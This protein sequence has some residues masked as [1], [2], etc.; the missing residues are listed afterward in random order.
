MA[1][2]RQRIDWFTNDFLRRF[3]RDGFDFNAAFSAGNNH[4][5]S[6][7]SVEQDSEINLARDVGG[8]GY[9]HFVNLATTRSGLVRDKDLT[10]HLRRDL[11]H[12]RRRLANM[13]PAFESIFERALA[14]SAGVNLRLNNNIDIAEFA[15]DLFRVVKGRRDPPSGG[16]YIEFLQQLFGL[17]FVNVHRQ[18]AAVSSPPLSIF[19][20]EQ[21]ACRARISN[22]FSHKVLASSK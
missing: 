11:A 9:E 12:F 6:C 7:G 15:R 19:S 4:R 8:F 16:R 17:V 3:R 1:A 10:Q 20:K 14:A 13:Y 18:G 22:G 2:T 5:R 21:L